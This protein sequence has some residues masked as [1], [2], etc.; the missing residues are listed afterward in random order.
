MK[1]VDEIEVTPLVYYLIGESNTIDD[2]TEL[3]DFFILWAHRWPD[4]Y[5]FLLQYCNFKFSLTT[6]NLMVLE[7]P[8]DRIFIIEIYE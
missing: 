7:I 4:V 6:R 5:L 2:V 1:K 3:L 8:I